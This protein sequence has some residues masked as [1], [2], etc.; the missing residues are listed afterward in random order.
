MQGGDCAE[1][2]DECCQET[3]EKKFKILLQ[4][5]LVIIWESRLPVVR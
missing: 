5:S 1:R 3:I 4:M 2:F